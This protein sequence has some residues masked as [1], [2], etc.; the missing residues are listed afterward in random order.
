MSLLKPIIM[1]LIISISLSVLL[2]KRIEDTIPLTT[3]GIIVYL[4]F[5]YILNI[6]NIGFYLLITISISLFALTLYKLLKDKASIKEKLL[7]IL[8]PGFF[9]FL[10][11]I[12]IIIPIT[13]TSYVGLWDELRLWGAYPK[14]L[15]FDGSIQLGDSVLLGESMMSYLPGMPLFQY[16]FLKCANSF[17]EPI[18]FFSYAVFGL[19][20][21]LPVTKNIK[22]K[23]FVMII[24]ISLLFVVLPLAFANNPGFDNL[25][26][27]KTL[28]IDP[29]LGMMFA[30]IMILSIN[31]VYESK[32]KILSFCLALASILLFKNTAIL[33][34][35]IAIISSILCELFVYKNFGWKKLIR[36][37][38]PIIFVIGIYLSW[39]LMLNI[40]DVYNQHT[41]VMSIDGI[42]NLL[43]KPTEEQRLIVANTMNAFNKTSLFILN[44]LGTSSILNF[45]TLFSVFIV[46]LIVI[47]CC[48]KDKHKKS[49]IIGSILIALGSILI[50]FGL[51]LL[52]VFSLKGVYSYG[53]YINTVM[54]ALLFFIVFMLLQVNFSLEKNM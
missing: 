27:Y 9:I 32:F 37:L 10:I 16:F 20:I 11:A 36:I 5:F 2:K 34:A 33:F 13:L 42:L 40:Y 6:L 21:M 44:I 50:A 47:S 7:N 53:R 45:F 39:K 4:Y 28:Y 23:N 19:S 35:I 26:Y 43:I 8:T 31:N 24:L 51:V 18:L 29:M 38:F 41:S 12:A 52:F 25:S 49:F 54:T 1:L 46:M 17:Y 30:Y 15:F 3:T 22:R 14:I 48:L